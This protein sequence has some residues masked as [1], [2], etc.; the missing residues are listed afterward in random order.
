MLIEFEINPHI[1]HETR[2][3]IIAM[4]QLSIHNWSERYQLTTQ[5]KLVKNRLRLCLSRDELYS[6]FLMT[7]DHSDYFDSLVEMTLVKDLN[8][9]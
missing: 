5:Q 6:F 4:L 2:Q 9:R 1:D 3:Y 7:F 8:N